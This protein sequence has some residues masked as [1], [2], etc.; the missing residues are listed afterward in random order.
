MLKNTFLH[1]SG[2]GPKKEERL[3]Q[4]GIQTWDEAGTSPLNAPLSPQWLARVQKEIAISQEHFL[5]Q[6]ASYFASRLPSQFQW[7]MFP[8]FRDVTAYLD[9]ETTGLDGALHDITVIGLYD[10][11]H[12]HH[13]IRGENLNDF[14]DAVHQYKVLVTFNGRCFDVP[15]IERFFR[16]K[17]EHAHIDLRF[18]LKSLGYGGGLKKC[19]MEMGI[20]REGLKGMDGFMAVLLWQHYRQT[21]DRKAR[22]TLLAYNTQD[23]VNLETLLVM[24]YNMKLKETPFLETHTLPT[25]RPP[26]IP[27]QED[28]QVIERIQHTAWSH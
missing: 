21:N 26:V 4:A 20:D 7:R 23:I 2:I 3:W 15:F 10:G 28:Q 1:I 16:T 9:I 25:P 14:E 27:F 18:M 8:E 17:L 19:E 24:A 22:D 13:F 12:V 11:N 5:D 6:D